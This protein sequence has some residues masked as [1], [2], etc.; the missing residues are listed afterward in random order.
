MTSQCAE[1]FIQGFPGS[2]GTSDLTVCKVFIQGFPGSGCDAAFWGGEHPSCPLLCLAH[3]ESQ[4][5][6]LEGVRVRMRTV[7]GLAMQF[8]E[9]TLI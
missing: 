3:P 9:A 4:C 5:K 7:Q 2:E 6:F 1:V 8:Q